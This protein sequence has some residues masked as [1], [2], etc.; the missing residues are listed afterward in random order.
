MAAISSAFAYTTFR[1]FCHFSAC[2]HHHIQVA[3]KNAFY[4]FENNFFCGVWE[5]QLSLYALHALFVQLCYH[6]HGEKSELF[7]PISGRNV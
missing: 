4:V 7:V 2:L 1:N 3:R 5:K 6:R